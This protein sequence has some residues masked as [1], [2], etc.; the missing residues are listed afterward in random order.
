MFMFFGG[1][2]SMVG[3]A[4]IVAGVTRRLGLI[5]LGWAGFWFDLASGLVW[6]LV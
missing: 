1:I 6:V 5:S 2:V 3:P 4:D